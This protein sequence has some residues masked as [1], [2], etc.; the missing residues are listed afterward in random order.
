MSIRQW[1]NDDWQGKN[2]R[3]PWYSANFTQ[4]I[5]CEVDEIGIKSENPFPRKEVT[6]HSKIKKIIKNS[7]N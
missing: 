4:R 3:T 7:R 5:L 6:P 1:Q 2:R